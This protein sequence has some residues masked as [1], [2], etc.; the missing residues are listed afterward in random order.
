MYE[1]IVKAL[2]QDIAQILKKKEEPG[3]TFEELSK[4]R[5]KAEKSLP[6]DSTEQGKIL[7]VLHEIMGNLQFSMRN[8]QEAEK[9][10]RIMVGIGAEMYRKDKQQHDILFAQTNLRMAVFYKDLINMGIVTPQPRK[11]NEAQQ[12]AYDASGKFFRNAIAACLE[13]IKAGNRVALELQGKCMGN[14]MVLKGAVGEYEE[15]IR[16][17][18]QLIKLE[19][20]IFQVT[21]D[22]P[23]AIELAQW[24]N[25]LA[26]IYS[27]HKDHVKALEMMEDCIYVLED[28]EQENP[29]AF[30][31]RLAS[32]YV[33]LGNARYLVPE[34]QEHAEEAYLT[35]L[36][37]Y[38]K[39]NE[40]TN[41]QFE[42]DEQQAC[43]VIGSYYQRTGQKDIAEKYLER[44][45]R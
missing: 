3:K 37:K 4:V 17:G 36:E 11:L 29:V 2:N 5:D 6:S 12:K 45:K 20:A 23:H 27:F 30:G 38:R 15:A 21:D 16:I 42:S 1:D 24:M 33:N 14:L 40:Q 19:K 34:E 43:S 35:G 8:P 26:S 44:G 7:A 22:A 41:G 10:Y 9:Q 18:E 13:K 31:V 25:T 28:K 32:C 39:L